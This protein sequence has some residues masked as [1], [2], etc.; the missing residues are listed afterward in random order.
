MKFATKIDFNLVSLATK[1]WMILLVA[2]LSLLTIMMV[3]N[4]GDGK[5]FLQHEDEAIYYCSAK[6][7]AETNS[8]QAEGCNFEDVSP[9]G[10]INWYGPG[11]HVL[12]GTLFK[13]FGEHP[14]V[15]QWFHYLL[16]LVI[17][18]LILTLPLNLELRLAY[19]TA[20]ALTQQ[21][22]VYVFTF[23]PESLMLFFATVLTVLLFHLSSYQNA[24]QKK[25]QISFIIAC[26]VFALFRITFVFWILGWVVLAKNRTS[27][28]IRAFIF[29]IIFLGSLV[30]MK[31]F[32]AP[33]YSSSVQK[34]EPL[35][36]GLIFQFISETL[37]SILNNLRLL[38]ESSD[39]GNFLVIGFVAA[40]CI[41]LF[42]KREKILW[43]STVISLALLVTFLGYYVVDE[44][45]FLKQT[46]ML[47]PLLLLSL[48]I[49][50]HAVKARY[51]IILVLLCVFP[52][53]LIMANKII[54]KRRI[55]YDHRREFSELESSF[56]KIPNYI[57]E[58][59][60]VI[61]W[62]Y[63]E[64]DYGRSTESLLSFSTRAKQPI[65]YTTNV[66][67]PD[68]PPETKFRTYNKLKIDYILSRSALNWPTLQKI[69]STPYFNLYEV[70]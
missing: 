34:I 50:Y 49:S 52:S 20:I 6:L 1:V 45:F 47:M 51:F 4:V 12:Y 8:I 14:P 43:P 28:F 26:L 17:V 25:Y 44:F 56:A 31:Y 18:G 40:S 65:L 24:K 29:L 53:R 42:I 48:V 7:F 70:K 38:F 54:E 32:L 39:I 19:A 62:C 64:Y 27:F 36:Q 61:L 55:E 37:H 33:S 58:G 13:I 30:Y 23:F 5:Y 16:S 2:V 9:I 41:T 66:V 46:A 69:H 59:P 35:H 15:F 57:R 63:D 11:Y 21:F 67:A 60:T 22:F 68:S 3:V 10:K